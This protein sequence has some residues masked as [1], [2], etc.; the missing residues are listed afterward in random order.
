MYDKLARMRWVAAL[1]ITSVLVAGCGAGDTVAENAAEK[2]IEDGVEADV[3]IDSDDGSVSVEGE[4]GSFSSSTRMPDTFPVDEVPLIDGE[5]VTGTTI[6]DDGGQVWTVALEVDGTA[7]EAFDTALS[8][9]KSAGFTVE[10]ESRSDLGYT[11]HLQS[12]AHAVNL[13]ASAHQDEAPT[14]SYFVGDPSA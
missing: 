12:G 6:E 11:A 10:F 3:D 2:A 8:L 1:A 4:D 7:E 14:V 13:T 5:V 9:L